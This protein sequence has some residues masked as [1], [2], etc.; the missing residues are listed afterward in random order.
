MG[1]KISSTTSND[2]R[3]SSFFSFI[4]RFSPQKP[5][6]DSSMSPVS[7]NDF[8]RLISNCISLASTRTQEYLVF[9]DP[10]GKLQP[11]PLALTQVF[12]MT[13][14]T[15]SVNLDLTDTFNC[16]AMTPEQRI[17]LGADWVW[18]ILEKP[19]K[20][21]KVQIAVQVLHLPEREEAEEQATAGKPVSESIQMARTE[22]RNKN[23][24]ECMV[25][26]CT[27]IGKDCYALFLFFG[28]R[29]DKANI[30]GV[31]SN[32]FAA[33]VGKC[34]TIDRALLENF[35]KGSRC[36]HS[37]LGMMQ[38]VFTKKTDEALTLMIKF[39]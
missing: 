3:N 32:N 13:Y 27:S 12:L 18:A 6:L 29:D 21:P 17:L 15:Q 2:K 24:Y 26:F 4:K 10:E 34:D 39:S 11:S 8:T 25:E 30:Y 14:I 22:S 1:Q 19:T 36:F 28:R 16:T 38:A 33:A 37:P 23:A 20:N 7:P 5:S 31:L 35:F 9:K